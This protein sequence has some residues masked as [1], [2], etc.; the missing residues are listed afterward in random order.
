[1]RAFIAAITRAIS[2]GSDPITLSLR[3]ILP[4]STSVI[5]RTY[6]EERWDFLVETIGSVLNQSYRPDQLILVV[7]HNPALLERLQTTFPQAITVA[8]ETRGSS[9]AFNTGVHHATGEI[10]A[11]IDDDAVAE[12]NWLETLVAHYS[13]D[14]VAGVGG[15]IIP[16]WLAGRPAWFPEEFLWVN[17]CTYRGLPDTV[18]PLRNLIGCNMS[19]RRS[20]VEQVG[21]FSENV[22]L[23]HQG[24]LPLGCEETELCI[25][26]RQQIPGA[27][28]LNEPK[29]IVHHKVPASRSLFHY[30]R[31]RC[32]LEGQSKAIISRLLGAQDG[33]SAESSY[34]LKVLPLGVL[35]G[36]GETLRGDK[37]G[38]Q[39]SGAIVVGLV[40]TVVSYL[41][42]RFRDA[43]GQSRA[44][45]SITLEQNV[46]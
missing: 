39:R 10:L 42:A 26:L 29:A 36:I 37:S 13:D 12:P 6:T 28:L 46:S 18:A 17:G 2:T 35:R 30:F 1:M 40:T 33:L 21:G 45:L 32:Y 24:K 27:V 19:L 7:D 11:F 34:T 25:R 14:K 3:I 38:V 43:V 9:A 20:L 23:G 15:K 4:P 5:I 16:N 44:A 41:Q 31:S 8:S 22:G